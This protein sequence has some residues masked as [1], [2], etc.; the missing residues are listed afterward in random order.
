M[1]LKPTSALGH[2]SPIH[3]SSIMR[4][5]SAALVGLVVMLVASST[6]LDAYAEDIDIEPIP[7]EFQLEVER[8][9]TAY[10]EA[11]AQADDFNN[12]LIQHNFVG[13]R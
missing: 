9:A 3:R 6:A 5:A 10:D 4:L 11:V 8:T 13:T 1:A 2:T 12:L 7:S